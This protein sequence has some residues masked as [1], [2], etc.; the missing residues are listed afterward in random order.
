MFTLF[1]SGDLG[2][3]YD[4]F[5]S[6][7]SVKDALA[8]VAANYAKSRWCVEDENGVIVATCSAFMSTYKGLLSA[9]LSSGKRAM[10]LSNDLKLRKFLDQCNRVDNGE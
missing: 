5:N 6:L 4:E 7:P 8:I 3:S 2:V 10:F 9:A 1:V